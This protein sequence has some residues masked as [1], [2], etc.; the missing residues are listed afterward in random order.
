MSVL[1]M[2]CMIQWIKQ[3]SL[4]IRLKKIVTNI[5][6]RQQNKLVNMVNANDLIK[7]YYW[8]KIFDLCFLNPDV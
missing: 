3:L 7:P 4:H 8:P 1:L 5:Q 6:N 2:Y